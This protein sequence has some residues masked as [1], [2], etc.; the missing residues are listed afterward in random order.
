MGITIMGEGYEQPQPDYYV[1]PRKRRE[2]DDK[3]NKKGLRG[4]GMIQDIIQLD[5]KL[6]TAVLLSQWPANPRTIGDTRARVLVCFRRVKYFKSLQSK[7][8]SI[9]WSE[10]L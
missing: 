7:F 3:A 4:V 10:F 9:D 2:R 1:K 5:R 6:A 8:S